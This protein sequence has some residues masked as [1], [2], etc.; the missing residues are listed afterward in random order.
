MDIGGWSVKK[1]SHKVASDVVKAEHYLHRKPPISF[2]FGLFIY[3]V[4]KGVITFG[5]PPSRHLQKSLCPSNPD[6]VLELNRFWVSDDLPH[7]TESMF[8]SQCLKLIP[9]RL[10]A[11]YADTA[12][13]HIGYV[14][15][16]SNWYYNGYTDMDRKTP[17][18]DYAVD[19]KHSRDAYRCRKFIRVRRLPK[20]RYWTVTGDKRQKWQLLKIAGW[21]K[22]S[23]KEIYPGG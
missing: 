20:Y 12:Y 3:D 19:G 1:I 5:T 13:G 10:I 9:P 2:A 7:N 14:Y 23:W 18:Y 11:S 21:Q 8:C 17:R 16:A 6:I 22:L 4:L 15:R